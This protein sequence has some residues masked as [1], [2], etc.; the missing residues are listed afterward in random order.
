MITDRDF[1]ELL[2]YKQTPGFKPPIKDPSTLK[3][4][5]SNLKSE[6]KYLQQQAKKGLIDKAAVRKQIVNIQKRSKDITAEIAKQ[7]AKSAQRSHLRSVPGGQKGPRKATAAEKRTLLKKL[8]KGEK[9]KKREYDMLRR[10]L[11]PEAIE[12][13]SKKVVRK[14]RGPQVFAA[15][16]VAI[17]LISLTHDW[18]QSRMNAAKQR[19]RK[20]PNKDECLKMYRQLAYIGRVKDL[21][22]KKRGYCGKTDNPAKCIGKV[23][24]KISKIQSRIRRG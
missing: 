22:R 10:T 24:Q 8:R 4:H 5:L 12:K 14:I 13:A 11:T 23:D 9:L 1:D 2:E 15:V 18:Y 3:D 20:A 19:C 17:T 16:I 7:K 21:E 6:T